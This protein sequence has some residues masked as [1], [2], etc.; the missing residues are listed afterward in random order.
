M[1]WAATKPIQNI[2]MVAMKKGKKKKRVNNR[3]ERARKK[4]TKEM[5]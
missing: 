3:K 5:L 4:K 1:G 2:T